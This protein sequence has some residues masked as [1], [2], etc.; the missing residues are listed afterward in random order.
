MNIRKSQ[1]LGKKIVDSQ[2]NYAPLIWMFCKKIFYFKMQK[3]FHKTMTVVYQSD[4][5]HKILVNLDNSFSL[6]QKHL[7]FLVSKTYKSLS[8]TNSKFT[9]SYVGYKNL[10][11]NLKRRPAFVLPSAKSTYSVWN[12]FCAF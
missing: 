3:I 1:S 5:P 6:H 9:W 11:S 7:R 4:E 8:K 10:S 12:E 2:I